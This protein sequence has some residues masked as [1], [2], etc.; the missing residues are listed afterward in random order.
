MRS[1][2]LGS[3]A[4]D[5]LFR[6]FGSLR[7]IKNK[8]DNEQKQTPD[9]TEETKAAPV[10]E[11]ATASEE[12][13]PS[14]EEEAPVSEEVPAPTETPEAPASE[15]ETP[16]SEEEAPISEEAP[17]PETEAPQPEKK[18]ARR[19]WVWIVLGGVLLLLLAALLLLRPFG[20]QAGPER[21][22]DRAFD[23]RTSGGGLVL[24]YPE[25]LTPLTADSAVGVYGEGFLIRFEDVSAAH[26][27]Q[28]AA[29]YTEAESAEAL[30][31]AGRELTN[32]GV[33]SGAELSL[34]EDADGSC[35]SFAF[36]A[37]GGSY[38]CEL[39]LFSVDGRLLLGLLECEPE[40][41]D[42]GRQ[43]Y[44]ALQASLTIE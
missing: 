34:N 43:L 18:P 4:A 40:R 22:L 27:D 39:R 20:G 31:N 8:M 21:Y 44:T 17:A 15:E 28:L 38:K 9:L 41:L 35:L 6:P 26:A 30:L 24:A 12:E 10:S 14:S 23:Q 36:D 32:A 7:G 25:G 5:G 29:G 19:A 16:S 3:G 37:D 33:L 13:T 42:G 1:A 2:I 11:E